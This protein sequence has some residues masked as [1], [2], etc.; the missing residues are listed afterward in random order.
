M[1]TMAWIMVLT[2]ILI[3]RGISKGRVLELP[4]DLRDTVIAGLTGDIAGLKEIG[5]RTGVGTSAATVTLDSVEYGSGRGGNLVTEMRRLSAQAGSRYVWGGESLGEGGYDCSG[6]VWASLK[7]LGVYN[8]P[9]FT[10][11]SF[12]TV[13]KQFSVK[14]S[15]PAPGDIVRWSNH[16]GVVTGKDRYYSALNPRVGIK[17]DAIH[18]H[19]GSPTYYRITGSGYAGGS[20][21]TAKWSNKAV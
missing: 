9:R 17:E 3:V 12:P 1:D 8:G 10:A 5:Q 16:M 6:L 7:S 19:K 4:Q 18:N 13:A 21:L 14:V 20:S 2:G 15:T 11:S